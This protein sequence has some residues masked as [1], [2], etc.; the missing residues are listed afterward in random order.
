MW[1]DAPQDYLH[2]TNPLAF[3]FFAIICFVSRKHKSVK[4]CKKQTNTKKLKGIRVYVNQ[5]LTRRK[6]ETVQEIE[7]N[8]RHV[9]KVKRKSEPE[10]T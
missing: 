2:M 6:A 3:F 5:D 10:T 7:A 1:E 4:V 9:R 8:S